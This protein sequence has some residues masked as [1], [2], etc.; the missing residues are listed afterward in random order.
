MDI[1]YNLK[2][3]RRLTPPRLSV[4]SEDVM[5]FAINSF[6]EGDDN[7]IHTV[8]RLMDYDQTGQVNIKE[9]KSRFFK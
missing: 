8:F 2:M 7:Q 5:D 9:F 4:N 1:K 6:L 3:D